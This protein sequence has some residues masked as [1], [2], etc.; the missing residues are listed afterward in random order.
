VLSDSRFLAVVAAQFFTSLVEIQYLAVL[1]LYLRDHGAAPWVFTG[2]VAL[3]GAL[4][5]LMELAVIWLVRGW[6][7]RI[8]I[9]L[10]SSLIGVGLSVFGF[11]VALPLVGLAT[12]LW[13]FGEM[14]SAS[15]VN[16]Y[17]GLV[18]PPRLAGRYYGMLAMGQT[19]GFAVGP[20]FGGFVY[21][22]AGG[23]VWAVCALGGGLALLGMLVGVRRVEA[24]QDPRGTER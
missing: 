11:G 12:L 20:A 16:A 9:A 6:S 8:R 19:A 1:P 15:A 2:V 21:D 3:N 24:H 10:G 22:R 5:I 7:L 23:A 4:V 17:P 18:A 13:T 14:I